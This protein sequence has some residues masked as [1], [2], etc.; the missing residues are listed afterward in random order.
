MAG[1][2]CTVDGTVN[3]LIF[4]NEENGYTV[5]RL[6]TTDGQQITVVG[7]IPCAAPGEELIVTGV[8]KHHPVHGAQVQ[9]ELVERYMPRTESAILSYLSSGVV[10]G[11]G[12]ATA[13]MLV[14]RFGEETLDVLELEPERMTTLKGITARKA[15]EI[16]ASFR[17][18]AG[19]RRLMEFLA[20]NQLPTALALKLFK[21]YGD[22]ASEEVRSNPYLLCEELFG[23]SFAAADAIALSDGV[24]ADSPARLEAAVL[25]TLMHNMNNG[26]VFL[27]RPKLIAAAAAMLE[28][29]EEPVEIALDALLESGK[30]VQEPVANVQACYMTSMY[31]A[32]TY[33]C[34]RMLRMCEEATDQGRNVEKIL[35][36]IQKEQGI[37]YA[38]QQRLAV[39]TAAQSGVFLLTGG[40]GTGKTT[41]VR[42]IVA[43]LERMGY[44][45][46]LA[47]PTGRAAKRLGDACAREAQTIHRMLGMSYS[48]ELG[49]V[50]FAKNEKEPLNAD[51]V[52]IDEMSMVDLSLMRSLLAALRPGCRLVMVGD[53]DQLPSVGAGNVFS[54]LIRSGRLAVVHLTEIFRQAQQSAIVRNA[55]AINRGEQPNLTSNQ[56]DFFFLRRRDEETVL[57]TIVELCKTRLPQNMGIEP[58]QIQ[59][60][61]PTRKGGAGTWALNRALQAALNPARPD[62]REKA[63][64]DTVFRQGDR[65]MQVKNDYDILWQKQDGAVGTGVFNGDVGVVTEIDPSGELLTVLFEDKT[66]TYTSEMLGELELAYAVTVH[67]AQGSEYRAVILAAMPCAAT[68]MVRNVL[69][70]AITRAKELLILVG[71]DQTICRMAATDRRSRRYSGLKV[72]LRKGEEVS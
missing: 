68:L 13:Q 61:S 32:E 3:S 48:E 50:T 45:V 27:P 18:Q 9:A 29:S 36:E 58:Q 57:R 49:E 23:V 72:R 44:A 52:I 19:M 2:H 42:G 5:L 62:R 20:R 64:G 39:E 34:R 7:C 51:A 43:M 53:A 16:A 30:L 66:A 11:V 38:A 40:P 55:H 8:W 59:V 26:H 37:V 24:E 12:P 4:Q 17:Y 1:E 33:V 71:D 28:L 63:F 6:D 31:E 22:K 46:E 10:K 69:Y 67:K 41:C 70:T 54:D 60:L 21:R 56:G 65:V 35:Q 14:S 25:F 15:Q 47:A